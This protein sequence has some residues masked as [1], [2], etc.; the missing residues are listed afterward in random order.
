MD[1]T[2]KMDNVYQQLPLSFF[3]TV[4]GNYGKIQDR[5][6][7]KRG[8]TSVNPFPVCKLYQVRIAKGGAYVINY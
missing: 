5:N 7:E 1:A 2:E 6:K 4:L 8:L 3:F